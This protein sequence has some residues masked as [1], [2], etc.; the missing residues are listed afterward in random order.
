M[1]NLQIILTRISDGN[2]RTVLLIQAIGTTLKKR[3]SLSNQTELFIPL[4]ITLVDVTSTA[5][6][7]TLKSM[8]QITY[9]THRSWKNLQKQKV[10][11]RNRF[12]TIQLGITLKNSSR[13]NY[14][15]KKALV[16]TP[17]GKSMSNPFLADWRVFLAFA[18]FTLEGGKPFKQRLDF[19]SW[20][21]I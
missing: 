1:C 13:K 2:I 14:I 10:V 3:T 21:W 15:A 12:T 9:K 8:R 16:S 4:R 7:V 5:L 18:E 17:N 20:A 19:S 11:V 6:N